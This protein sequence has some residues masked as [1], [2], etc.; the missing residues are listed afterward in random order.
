M[1]VI[2]SHI[3]NSHY[4]VRALESLGS[5][6]TVHLV[7]NSYTGELKGYSR[8]NP[9]INYIRPA[10]SCHRTGGG[11]SWS[12]LCCASSWNWAMGT[13]GSSW[14]INV[15]PDVWLWP[16]A[17]TQF[18]T[19]VMEEVRIHEK[20]VLVRSTLG[21]N[22][23]AGRVMALRDLGGF[24]QSFIPCGGEDEDMLVRICKAGEQWSQANVHGVHMDGGHISR[25]DGYC[26]I[27]TFEEKHG[28][29]PNSPE[30]REIIKGGRV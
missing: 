15:N 30:Y 5:A 3:F 4:T 2:M 14:I 7:D 27:K 10:M 29:S 22:V 1:E 18:E 17:L 9:H 24:D 28:F 21:F 25:V 11:F 13:A 12:P 8:R 6:R 19:A 20:V 23:W 26:N 16:D